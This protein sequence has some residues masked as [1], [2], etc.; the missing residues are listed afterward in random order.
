MNTMVAL[1]YGPRWALGRRGWRW[2]DDEG[3]AYMPIPVDLRDGAEDFVLTAAMAGVKP[4]EISIHIEDDTI[5]LRAE[6]H[7]SEADKTEF[8]MHERYAGKLGRTLRLP[9][10]LDAEKAEAS[11]EAGVLTL[12]VPKA[13]SARSKTIKVSVK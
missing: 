12:R 9:V 10:S 2:T 3:V 7:A 4:E 13:A 11:L 8:L 1:E 6:P 5:S